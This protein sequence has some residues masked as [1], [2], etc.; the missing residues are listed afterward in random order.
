MRGRQ[1]LQLPDP[2]AQAQWH[3][4]GLVAPP[5]GASQIRDWTLPPALEGGLFTTEPL[6]T[7]FISFFS[8]E[9]L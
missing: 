2:R 4:Q 1:E 6:G 7:P 5:R 9:M 3:T 8:Y